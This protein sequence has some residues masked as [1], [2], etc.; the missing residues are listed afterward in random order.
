MAQ[1]RRRAHCLHPQC[2]PR[3]GCKHSQG[4]LPAVAQRSAQHVPHPG[5]PSADMQ[6]AA[7]RPHPLPPDSPADQCPQRSSQRCLWQYQLGLRWCC[8]CVLQRHGS[9]SHCTEGPVRGAL[10]PRTVHPEEG[11]SGGRAA[12]KRRDRTLC[13]VCML[14]VVI[15][16]VLR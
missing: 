2:Q 9:Q 13:Q 7:G 8:R 3:P 4:G 15:Y 6:G 1:R 12:Q 10:S 14:L 16:L 11:G 5:D